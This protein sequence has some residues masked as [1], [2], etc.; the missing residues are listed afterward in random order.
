MAPEQNDHITFASG[1]VV[2][3]LSGS[4]LGCQHSRSH[5]AGCSSGFLGYNPGLC[6]VSSGMP[7]QIHPAIH[8]T[9][10]CMIESESLS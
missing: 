10:M 8:P 5:V 1:Y 3:C 9:G 7:S 2:R 6:N 4:G